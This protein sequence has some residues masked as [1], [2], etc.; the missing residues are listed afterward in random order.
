LLLVRAASLLAPSAERAEW[1]REWESEI[2][3]AA[4]VLGRR[5]C[6]QF[7]VESKLWLFAR[8][9][10]SDAAWHRVR[11]LTEARPR[12]RRRSREGAGSPAFCLMA[13]ALFILM[14]AAASG[15]SAP[16]ATWPWHCP[17]KIPC[18]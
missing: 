11:Q 4:R 13:L 16:L 18:V 10:V 17:M 7:V 15:G 6:S 12:L 14:I 2:R 1:R 5:G 8:G 9:S 3:N